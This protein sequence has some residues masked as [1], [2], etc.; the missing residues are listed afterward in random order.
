LVLLLLLLLLLPPS[1][2]DHRWQPMKP[3][4]LRQQWPPVLRLSSPTPW[5]DTVDTNRT[6]SPFGLRT[7]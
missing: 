5:R 2:K 6:D 3:G 1:P 7:G 4:L